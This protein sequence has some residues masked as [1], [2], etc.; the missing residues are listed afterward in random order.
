MHH[1]GTFTTQIFSRN[2][3]LQ[4]Y[5]PCCCQAGAKLQ[6]QQLRFS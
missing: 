4:P 6:R 1:R 3:W 5:L 2:I